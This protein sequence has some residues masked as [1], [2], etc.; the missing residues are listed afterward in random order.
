V[1][2]I[3]LHGFVGSAEDFGP[4]RERLGD[5]AR[6][7]APDWPGHGARSGLREAADFT[8]EAHL[9]IIDATLASTAGPV[10]L[11][12][13]SMGGRILQHWLATRRPALPAGSR[14]VLLS[15]GPGIAEPAERSNRLAGDA[16][17]ARLLREE[18]IARFLHYWHSQTMFHPMLRLPREQLSPILRRRGSADPV[19]LA[20][21][22]EGVGAGAL[23]DT[24]D[25]LAAIHGPVDIVVGALD[26]KYADL[27]RQMRARVPDARLH[28]LPD[29][30]HAIHL[31]Q[32]GELAR[33][34]LDA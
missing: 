16:A 21:S 17:V 31:E 8:L 3:L 12:G 29:A 10:G 25:A 19:G 34:L 15:T 11:L 24:W 1:N 7:L 14:I 9:A 28:L 33:I 27:A 26:S 6:C 30:G 5:T 22:L 4:L 13:Y 2:W 23:A 32:P 18:G 20:L